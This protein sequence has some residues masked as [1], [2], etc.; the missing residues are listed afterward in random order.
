VN[1]IPTISIRLAG[2]I[3]LN[4]EEYFREAFEFAELA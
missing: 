1:P 3:L 2:A 4:P